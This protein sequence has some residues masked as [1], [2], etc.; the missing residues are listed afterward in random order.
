MISMIAVIW[1]AQFYQD[2]RCVIVVDSSYLPRMLVKHACTVMQY[3]TNDLWSAW[4]FQAWIQTWKTDSAS[5]YE[6]SVTWA[7]AIV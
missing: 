6:M 2:W 3:M 7:H 5:L 4:H 1:N